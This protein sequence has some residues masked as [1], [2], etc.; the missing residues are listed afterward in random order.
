MSPSRQLPTIASTLVATLATFACG[1]TA[2]TTPPPTPAP[3]ATPTLAPPAVSLDGLVLLLHMDEPAWSGARNEVVD[4]SG[5]GHNGTATGGATTV[6]AGRFGRGGSFPG[7]GGCVQI[8]DTPDL[9]PDMALTLSAWT[10]VRPGGVQGIITKRVDYLSQSAYAFFFDVD[11]RLTVDIDTE[12]D[13]FKAGPVF[14]DSRWTHVAAVYDG[15]QPQAQR[16]TLYVDGA[17]VG[18][19]FEKSSVITP[20]QSPLWV[21]CLALSGPAQGFN[22]TLDEVAVWHRALS[23]AEIA[24]LANGGA[25]AR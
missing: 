17:K 11:N 14:A 24:A 12:N 4:S 6:A 22:G 25:I 15:G 18:S 2:V 7:G 13:R 21:G 19:G 9:R 5:L 20:F 3:T 10:F 16:T 23:S 1:S 8:A